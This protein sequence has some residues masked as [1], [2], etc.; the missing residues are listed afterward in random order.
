MKMSAEMN[1]HETLSSR[2]R[3]VPGL[4]LVLIGALALAANLTDYEWVKM[5]FLPALGLIFIV[6]GAVERNGGLLIPGGILSG[7]GLG[8]VL[9]AGPLGGVELEANGGIFF[10]SFALGFLLISLL[11]AIFTAKVQ[12]WPIIPAA[13]LALF[14]AALLLGG[15]ALEALALVGQGWPVILIIIGLYLLLWRRGLAK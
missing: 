6:W 13:F 15:A 8:V 4:A 11:S 5:L 9:L 2:R 14:G 1:T 12:W 7:L 10:L 3:L